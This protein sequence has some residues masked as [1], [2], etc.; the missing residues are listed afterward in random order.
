MEDSN[1]FSAPTKSITPSP[2]GLLEV[3]KTNSETVSDI[4]LSRQ[5]EELEII[6]K[7]KCYNPDKGDVESQLLSYK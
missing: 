2:D 6:H 7:A 5:K 3:V 4:L 1:I